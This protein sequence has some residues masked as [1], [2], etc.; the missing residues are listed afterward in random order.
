MKKILALTVLVS[1][2]GTSLNAATVAYYRFSGT[3]TAPTNTVINDLAG[4]HNGTVV[5]GDLVYGTDPLMGGYLTFDCD[6]KDRIVIPHSPDLVFDASASYTFEAVIRMTQSGTGTNGAIL[7]KGCDVSNP[8]S[9]YWVRHQGNGTARGDIEGL[10]A[11]TGGTENSVTSTTTTMV[12][13]GSWHHVAFV[14]DGAAKKLRIYIDGL[15]H[16]TSTVSTT[17]TVGGG[18]NDPLIIGEF[19]TLPVNRS[20]GGDIAAVRLSDTALAPEDFLQ[21]AATYISNITPADGSMFLPASTVAGFE[22]KSP[23]IG[24][25]SSSIKVSLNGTDISSQLSFAGS[26]SDWSVTL[27]ALSANLFCSI[28]IEVTDL[29]GNK[30]TGATSFNTF[31]SGLVFIEGEDYNFQG[32]QFIDNPQLSGTPGAQN[33]LDRLGIEGIDYHQTNTTVTALYRIGDRV[34]TTLS[35]DAL[36]Q[37]YIDAQA[38]DPGVADYVETETGNTEWLNY[39]R[40][41]PANTYRVYARVG[42]AGTAPTT[43]SLDEVTS[44]SSSTSQTLFPIG[45]FKGLPTGAAQSYTFIPL[46]DAFGQEATVRL[47]GV[48]ALRLTMVSGTIGLNLNYLLFVP[49]G[50]TEPPYLAGL[51]PASGADNELPNLTIKANIRNGDSQVATGNIGM[52]VNGAS[53]TP[54]V[55]PASAGATVSYTPSTLSTGLYS[56]TLTFSD[57]AS[58]SFTNQWQFRVANQAVRGYWKFD[59]KAAGNDAS[60]DVGSFL[61]FSGNERNGTSSSVPPVYV[62]GSPDYGNTSALRFN[63]GLDRIVVPDVSGAFN[64]TNSF[65]MEAVLRTTNTVAGAAIVA[66]NGTDGEG[67]YWWRMPGTGAKSQQIWVSGKGVTGTNIVNDGKWHHVA[68]VYDAAAGEIRAYFNYQLENSLG[69]LTITNAIGRPNDLT[70]G[71][72]W[73]G[74]SEFI[75]DV[76]FIRISSGALAPAEFVQAILLP[77]TPTLT[78]ISVAAGNFSFSFAT[79]AGHS[80][81]VLSASTLG[82]SWSEVETFAGT[83]GSKTVSYPAGGDRKFY[84]VRV[85]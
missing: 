29:G 59:E 44:G 38:T 81:T 73:N 12:N 2:F 18:D 4:A 13:D 20:F 8:D 49:V 24:V 57:S 72:F 17:G 10:G 47:S 31:S 28:N 76:D 62:Q 75:G 48:K 58:K 69:G 19:G 61:D 37:E 27:P 70:I 25:A 23:S 78:G 60:T 30:V 45:T 1:L 5:G 43:I 82:G 21:L 64:F 55:T 40:T 46:V 22:V 15:L 36:R 85:E 41:F 26:T 16:S 52:K 11:G 33:Y 35:Q 42:K 7:S 79:Q 50:E 84:R 80:Y 39:T 53:V 51:S 63:S 34:G 56:V 67:E 32:G 66:K 68:V 83:D 77:Q 54:T 6:G 14:C 74:G 3:G 71:S 65:T 9:Q